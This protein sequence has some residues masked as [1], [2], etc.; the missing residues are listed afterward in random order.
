MAETTVFPHWCQLPALP[1]EEIMFTS[2]TPE[3]GADIKNGS[4]SELNGIQ[5]KFDIL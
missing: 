3:T 2:S 1:L 5:S 4:D